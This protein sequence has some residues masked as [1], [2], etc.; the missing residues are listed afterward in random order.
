MEDKK[1]MDLLYLIRETLQHNYATTE[2][3]SEKVTTLLN[4]ADEYALQISGKRIMYRQP[5]SLIEHLADPHRKKL[6]KLEPKN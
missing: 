3:A 1:I 6:P 2:I 4:E 5:T